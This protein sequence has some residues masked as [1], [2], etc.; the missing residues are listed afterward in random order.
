MYKEDDLIPISVLTHF[1]YCERRAAL[2]YTEQMWCENHFTAEGQILHETVHKEE[3]ESRG[4]CR[5]ARA[6][7]MHSFNLGLYG[8]SDVVEF[9]KRDDGVRVPSVDGLWMPF[10]VEYKRGKPKSDRCDEIQL[11]AQAL[12]L[13]EMLKVVIPEG[14]LFYGTPR[15]R[16]SVVFDDTLRDETRNAAEKLHALIKSGKTPSAVFQKKCEN[17]SLV[18][19]CMPKIEKIRVTDTYIDKYIS[20]LEEGGT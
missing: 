6:L 2:V 18:E 13:E 16:T 4:N 20:D 12:C 10:P 1:G 5:I 9:H 15:R 3:V 17:C 14:A 8:K 11:C 19:I 7:Y